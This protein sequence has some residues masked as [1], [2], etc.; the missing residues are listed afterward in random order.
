MSEV[1]ARID[2]KKL[3]LDRGVSQSKMAYD[4]GIP[5]ARLNRFINGWIEIR[6]EEEKRILDYL[7]G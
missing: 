3:L 6:A 4:V 1:A 7:T 2:L 5:F